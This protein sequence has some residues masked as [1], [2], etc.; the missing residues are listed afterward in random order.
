MGTEINAYFDQKY[1]DN[2]PQPFKI[3]TDM[4]ELLTQHERMQIDEINY[5][6]RPG[7]KHAEVDSAKTD[8]KLSLLKAIIDIFVNDSESYKSE[9]ILDIFTHALEIFQAHFETSYYQEN[10][11]IKILQVVKEVFKHFDE[12]MV[13]RH[14]AWFS[15]FSKRFIKRAFFILVKKI[16]RKSKENPSKFLSRIKSTF[17]KESVNLTFGTRL[18]IRQTAEFLQDL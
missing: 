16:V 1:L 11:L 4:I 7:K 17:G 5:R 15:K 3:D 18:F 6:S 10:E 2:A 13:T 9:S 12:V 14:A 8:F